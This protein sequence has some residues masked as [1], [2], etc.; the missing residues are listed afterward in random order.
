MALLDFHAANPLFSASP[1]FPQV[2]AQAPRS[3]LKPGTPGFE[4]KFRS[5]LLSPFP[6]LCRAESP[7]SPGRT[8]MFR[9][10]WL[11]PEHEVIGLSPEGS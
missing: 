9:R 3:A 4:P 1:V 6:R 7:T 11:F 8:I 2:A 10:A 5:L